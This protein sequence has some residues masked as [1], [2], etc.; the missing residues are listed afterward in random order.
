MGIVTFVHGFG[1]Y[2]GRYAY[3]AKEFAAKGYE[4]HTMDQ[5]GNGFSEGR[6]AVLESEKVFVSDL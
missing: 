4:F 3:L 1:D 2:S 5:R 6:K